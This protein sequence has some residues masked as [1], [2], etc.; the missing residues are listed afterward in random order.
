[1]PRPRTLLPHAARRL[2]PARLVL[3]ASL[4]AC[5]GASAADPTPRTITV[6][7][8]DGLKSEKGDGW[9]DKVFKDFEKKTGIK[10]KY[11]EGGSG[12]VVQRA[13]RER[14]NTQA[15]VLVTLP[16]FIQQADGKGLL[17]TPTAPRAPT[18]SPARTR[19]RRQVD[20]G[21]QQLLLL[22][23]QQEGAEAGPRHLAGP[24]GRQVQEQAPVLHAG[25]RRRRHRRPHQGDARL[26][27]QGARP[28]T[29]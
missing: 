22:H 6:Y 20:L 13:A 26:R 3:A 8:A 28:W 17:R 11:V 27:R 7:S 5:G 14:A 4:T 16:P 18:R 19:P 29:T 1:M 2:L 23:L 24:A 21:R 12:E 9:Y 25:R 10:V 15:D